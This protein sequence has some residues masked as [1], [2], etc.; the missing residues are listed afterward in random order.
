MSRTEA[1][2]RLKDEGQGI[3][4]SV[5]EEFFPPPPPIGPDL[6][7]LV[8]H[9]RDLT[10]SEFWYSA[11]LKIYELTTTKRIAK[12]GFLVEAD[13]APGS[14]YT[15]NLDLTGTDDACICPKFIACC[16]L[17][18]YGKL[19]NLVNESPVDAKIEEHH[20]E[21]TNKYPARDLPLPTDIPHSLHQ[22]WDYVV[23]PK[24]KVKVVFTNGHSTQTAHF[25]FYADYLAV[26]YDY[27]I[28]LTEEVYLPFVNRLES[29]IL[30]PGR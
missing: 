17:G 26:P 28:W 19:T 24:R 16:D 29:L 18:P 3:L 4:A 6:T 27:A 1:I 8:T 25:V 13:V 20:P 2:S 15:Y 21:W 22:G 23:F 7:L 12:T 10:L 9:L 30:P 11:I 14:S 5:L